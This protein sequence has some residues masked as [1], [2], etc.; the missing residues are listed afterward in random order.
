VGSGVAVSVGDGAGVP[1]AMAGVAVAV[2][3]GVEGTGVGEE[4][5]EA[6]V[7][8]ALTGE[9]VQ[10]AVRVGVGVGVNLALRQAC[11]RRPAAP[12]TKAARK[13]RRVH[14]PLVIGLSC[15]RQPP[16]PQ[17]RIEVEGKAGWAGK[18]LRATPGQPGEP[19]DDG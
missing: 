11:K 9:G 7:L 13:R 17:P 2:P 15:C 6:V 10:V 19:C 16:V 3:V 14:L 5:A 1:L 12:L 18:P 4:P 8:V